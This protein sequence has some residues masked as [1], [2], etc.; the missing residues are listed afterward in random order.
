MTNYVKGIDVNYLY[1]H[2]SVLTFNENNDIKYGCIELYIYNGIYEIYKIFLNDPL[3]KK[4][5]FYPI[6][7]P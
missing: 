5:T 1:A 3:Y 4:I 6:N 2:N 7:Q